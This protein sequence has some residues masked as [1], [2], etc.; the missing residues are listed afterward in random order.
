MIA[1]DEKDL[2]TTSTIDNVGSVLSLHAMWMM[3]TANYPV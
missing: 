3:P 2:Y 1:L